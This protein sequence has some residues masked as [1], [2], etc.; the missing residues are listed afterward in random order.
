[1][2]SIDILLKRLEH[3]EPFALARFNDGEMA[4]VAMPGVTVARGDQYVDDSLRAAL[5]AS[6][7]HEQDNYWVGMPCSVCWPQH[8]TLAAQC[9][10]ADYPHL[11]S[12]VVLTNRNWSRVT[13]TLPSLMENWETV[14]VT[15]KDQD[16]NALEMQGFSLDSFLWQHSVPFKNAWAERET[17]FK[18]LIQA[19]Q[20]ALAMLSCGPLSRVLAH[21]VFEARPDMTVLDI[22]SLLDCWTRDVW[23]RCHDGTLPHCPECN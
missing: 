18:T 7:V 16:L 1:M 15:G 19:P 21:R 4:G 17:A 2:Q 13:A 5:F 20:G 12:A 11:T 8:R 23:L 6:L 10:K 3:R 9:V 14:W 22:G